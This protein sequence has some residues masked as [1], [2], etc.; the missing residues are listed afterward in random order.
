MGWCNFI[1]QHEVEGPTS[2]HASVD[3]YFSLS[4]IRLMLQRNQKTQIV[5]RH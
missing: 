5:T 4:C 1:H 3:Y 2:Y